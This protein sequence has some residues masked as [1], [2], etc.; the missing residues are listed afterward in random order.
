MACKYNMTDSFLCKVIQKILYSV[1]SLLELVALLFMTN[2]MI[3]FRCH[4]DLLKKTDKLLREL[5]N[6]DAQKW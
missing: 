3:Y 2:G 6:L 1:H 5:K 4:F